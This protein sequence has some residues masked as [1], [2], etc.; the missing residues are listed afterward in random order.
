MG[1]PVAVLNSGLLKKIKQ[2]GML[3]K[4]T[5]SPFKKSVVAIYEKYLLPSPPPSPYIPLG[6]IPSFLLQLLTAGGLGGCYPYPLIST[7]EKQCCQVMQNLYKDQKTRQSFLSRYTYTH[8]FLQIFITLY[9][10]AYHN[11]A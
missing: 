11:T 8:F 9:S 5:I 3:S 10:K 4:Y 6:S 7:N 2:I 1:S